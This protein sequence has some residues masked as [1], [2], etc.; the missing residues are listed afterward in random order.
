MS[1][2]GSRELKTL[3]DA[4]PKKNE[5]IKFNGYVF[6]IEHLDKKRIKQVKLTLPGGV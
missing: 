6:T 1:K 5:R 2:G 3:N 4:F